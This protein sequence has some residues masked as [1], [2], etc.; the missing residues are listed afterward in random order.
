MNQIAS[1]SQL[2]MSFLRWALV[3]IPAIEFLGFV[4]GYLSNSGYDNR[5]FD[6]LSKPALVPP[7]WVFG[8]VW[9]TLYLLMALALAMILHARGARGRGLAITLF[10]VQLCINLVWSPLFFGAHQATLAFY[11][12]LVILVLATI[13]TI[14]FGR[15]RSVAAW[16]MVP[17]LC[18]L[19]FASGLAFD[20]D[21]MNPDAETLVPA[22]VR[23]QI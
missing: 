5:W 8:T 23:T 19:G 20:I 2:R 11:L 4:S 1:R 7:G 21:R 9:P 13:T 12:I 6:A 3:T 14:L 10:I 15:I 16:L 18:W 22:A 17:Y